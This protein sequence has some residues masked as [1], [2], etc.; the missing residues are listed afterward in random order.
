MASKTPPPSA[1]RG[2]G[3]PSGPRAAARAAPHGSDYA[4]GLPR[5]T[6]L[7]AAPGAPADSTPA[8]PRRERDS[9][10]HQY[11]QIRGCAL[12]FLGGDAHWLPVAPRRQPGRWRRRRLPGVHRR[13]V[14]L[15]QVDVARDREWRVSV[16]SLGANLVEPLLGQFQHFRSSPSSA[17]RSPDGVS[18]MRIGAGSHDSRHRRRDARARRRR[19]RSARRTLGVGGEARRDAVQETAGTR[20]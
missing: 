19:R 12:L 2:D 14:G 1:R 5:P 20:P 10:K 7:P 3:C 6:N 18:A 16:L 17:T 9:R 8:F 4:A 11:H 15:G 13:E